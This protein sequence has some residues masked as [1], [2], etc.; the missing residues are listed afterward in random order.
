MIGKLYHL[1]HIVE[2][3]DATDRLYFEVFDCLRPYSNYEKAASRDASIIIISDQ[4][5]EPIQPSEDPADAH[6]P[7]ASFRTQYGY[8]LHSIAWYVDDIKSFAN[9]LLDHD[10]RLTGLSGRPVTDPKKGYAVW[11]NPEDTGAI[12]EFAEPG[13]AAD[14]RLHQAYSRR[15][16]R[17]HPLAI[18]HT[19]C[20]TVLLDNLETADRIYRDALGGTRIHVDTSNAATPRAYYAVGEDTVIEA[21]APTSTNTPE[22]ADQVVA[23]NAVHAVTFA[24][25][26]LVGACKFLATHGISVTESAPGQVWLNLDPSHGL[27]MGLTDRAIPGD[28]RNG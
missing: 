8:R 10:I 12:L 20:V 19:A 1:A 15:R 24:T 13:F 5:L 25:T 26:D 11:T 7:L 28:P 17:D 23:G 16:W 18:T 21:V 27:R 6:T 3:L 2:D 9:R 14:P 4:C 22:G